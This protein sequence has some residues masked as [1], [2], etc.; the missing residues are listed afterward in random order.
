MKGTALGALMAI[1]GMMIHISVDFNL[2]PTAN[3]LTFIL[4]LFLANASAV[5]PA[6][7]SLQVHKEIKT[8]SKRE[9]YD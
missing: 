8:D 5:L 6:T 2:Q 9:V 7:G 1:I 4:I 3:A